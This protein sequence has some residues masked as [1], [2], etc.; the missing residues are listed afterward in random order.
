M[1]KELRL[2]IDSVIEHARTEILK[3]N[4]VPSSTPNT[5]VRILR[6]EPPFKRQL[7]DKVKTLLF[8]EELRKRK[9]VV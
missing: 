5:D 1:D 2:D 6:L 4:N 7:Q 9:L 8:D 3:A